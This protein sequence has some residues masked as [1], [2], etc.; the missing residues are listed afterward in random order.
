MTYQ[1]AKPPFARGLAKMSRKELKAYFAW[2]MDVLPERIGALTAEIKRTPGLETWEPDF[3]PASLDSL[4]VWFASQVKARPRTPQEMAELRDLMQIKLPG[5]EPPPE[6]LTERTFS[7]A[8][9]VGMYLSQVFLK[10]C[11]GVSWSQVLD[12]KSFVDYGHPVLLGIGPVR[13][14]PLKLVAT[15]AYGLADRSRDANGLRNVYEIWSRWRKDRPAIEQPRGQSTERSAR[16][17]TRSA[18]RPRPT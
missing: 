3:T 15:L 18:K 17:P 12:D 2:F 6:E 9:D 7:L 16:S 5:V 13:C 1:L 14:S 11:D 4:G 8:F 10:N